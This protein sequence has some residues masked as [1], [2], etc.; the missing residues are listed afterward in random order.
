MCSGAR[1]ICLLHLFFL[2]QVDTIYNCLKQA[3]MR[4][5]NL[6]NDY[7]QLPS[8]KPPD[9]MNQTCRNLLDILPTVIFSLDNAY[10]FTFLNLAWHQYTGH[11][12]QHSLGQALKNFMLPDEYQ[13]F[14]GIAEM[15]AAP[16]KFQILDVQGNTVAF[17]LTWVG[18]NADRL[19]SMTKIDLP[20]ASLVQ[21]YLALKAIADT[22]PDGIVTFN[23]L[24]CVQYVNPAFLK[25]T[26]LDLQE[27]LNIPEADFENRLLTLSVRKGPQHLFGNHYTRVYFI[28]QP[29]VSDSPSNSPPHLVLGRTDKETAN[30]DNPKA[31]YFRNISQQIEADTLRNQL[32]AIAAHE[33]RTP[34]ASVFGFSE[35][36]QSQEFD[37]ETTREITSTIYQQ[38]GS[39]VNMLNKLLDLARIESSMG[40]DFKLTPQALRPIVQQIAQEFRI[41]GDDRVVKLAQIESD[42]KVLVDAD[43]LRQTISTV[44]CN[45][46]N[47]SPDGGEICLTIQTRTNAKSE[48]EIGILI[49]DHGIGMSADECQR[50]CDRFWRANKQGRIAGS[51]LGMSIA[52]EIMS[53]HQ[54][55]IDITSKPG[56]GT[57]VGLWLKQYYTEHSDPHE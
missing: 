17:E 47:Y 14:Q 53:L 12:V 52:K 19:Y 24:G 20:S 9:T 49:S 57:T 22:C 48:A 25:I 5:M 21:N 29:I 32:L 51:G 50:I 35:L 16:Q 28:D 41:P 36:L 31:S 30:P 40:L 26:M 54:G 55:S 44:L 27:L 8:E 39:L 6:P 33:L 11:L 10:C 15:T 13:R 38:T 45:A 4:K 3:L 23:R 43:K 1:I 37:R 42:Y 34:M 7:L 18:D 56:A 46:Y 2:C